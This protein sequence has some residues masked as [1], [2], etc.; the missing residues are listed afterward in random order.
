MI[1]NLDIEKAMI[2][3]ILLGKTDYIP[4][5]TEED[6]TTDCLRQTYCAMHELYCKR[7]AI[8][9]LSVSEALPK[10]S[11]AL[12]ILTGIVDGIVTTENSDYYYQK[13]KDYSARRKLEKA[14]NKIIEIANR[15]DMTPA[16]ELKSEAMKEIDIPVNDFKKKKFDFQSVMAAT[17]DQIDK[18]YQDKSDN[19]YNTGFIDLDKLTAGLHPEELTIVAA[20]PGVGKTAYI[21]N[22]LAHMAP[23]GI[24]S[25]LISREMSQTQLTKRL[26][27][28]VTPLDGNKLR[29]CKYLSDEDLEK[30]SNA[31]GD[32][33]NWDLIINDELATVQEIRTYCRELKSKGC[34]DLLVVDY[35]QLCR[36]SSKNI[37][38]RHEIEEVSRQFKEMSMEFGIPVVVLS[39]LS[40]E[41][42]KNNREPELHDLRE[43][44][45]I[46]QDADNVIF[47]HV[48]K[49]T[50]ETQD[51]FDIKVIVGKQRNGP[52][53]YIKLRY[54]RKTFRM[55]NIE[56]RF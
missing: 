44:G 55:L 16:H 18:E 28:N 24:K 5:L 35:L 22:M 9:I 6:F 7:K 33:M 11:N 46:E 52:T 31:A 51:Q 19:I 42:A 20:R 56:K 40:R 3:C 54:H 49:D 4:K 21:I 1:F 8:D 53:G 47:L 30:I 12:E 14:A 23:R 36:S 29:M 50:D 27:A 43:S 2:A 37:D 48:P 13:I 15:I 45:S 25:V 10:I 41:N 38:R 39:Q 32:M 26:I 17:F 34:L